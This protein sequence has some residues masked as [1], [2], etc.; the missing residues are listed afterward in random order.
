MT[1][2]YIYSVCYDEYTGYWNICTGGFVY[3]IL[4]EFYEA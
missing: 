2:K 1:I 3:T 4:G